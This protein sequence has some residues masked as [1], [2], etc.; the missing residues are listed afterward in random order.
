MASRWRPSWSWPAS[1]GR[2]GR[3]DHDGITPGSDAGGVLRACFRCPG[4]RSRVAAVSRA[5]GNSDVILGGGAGEFLSAARGGHRKDDRDI[6]AEMQAKGWELVRSKAEL[7]NAASF[8]TAPLA[9]FFSAGAVGLQQPDRVGGASNRRSRIWCGG[10]SSFAGPWQGLCAGGGMPGWPRRPRNA[11]KESTCWWRRWRSIT[12]S[13]RRRSMRG[14]K[15]LILAVG[16]HAT[17][18]LSLNGY[19]FV[20]DHGVGLLGL[21][22]AGQPAITWATG[23]N[24]PGSRRAVGFSDAFGAEHGRRRDGGRAGAGLGEDPGI[25]R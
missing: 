11:T 14:E 2:G 22:A 24:G 19:P 23:P 4:W 1:K 3:A 7:E 18:G 15:S 16:K 12:P 25:Y 20:Q 6:L 13:R 21:N 8:R 9:G 10:R 17:G 5:G